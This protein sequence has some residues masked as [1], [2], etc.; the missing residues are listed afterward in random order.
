MPAGAQQQHRPMAERREQLLDAAV[1]VMRLRGVAA[2]T[3]RAVTTTAGLPHGAFHYCFHSKDDLFDAL[4]ERELSGSL[5]EAWDAVSD[6]GEAQEG[7]AVALLTYL[8]HVR[9]DPD[10]QLLIRELT[11]HAARAPDGR[12]ALRQHQEIAARTSDLVTRWS[13]SQRLTW[14]VPLSTVAELLVSTAS[15]LAWTWLTTRDDQLLDASVQA[16]ANSISAL[17]RVSP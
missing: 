7:I 9:A 11:V 10:Y 4:L 15:G 14:T 16:F 13:H 17:A 2:A 12:M 8:D 6:L 3:T 1:E 5:M